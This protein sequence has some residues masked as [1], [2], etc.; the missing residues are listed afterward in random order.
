[1][2]V[3]EKTTIRLT[4]TY[5]NFRSHFHPNSTKKLKKA[6]FWNKGKRKKVRF[7]A[8]KQFP[9]KKIAKKTSI[10]D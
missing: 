6:S 7:F 3:A 9:K 5:T 1:M 8:K 2:K 4:I 10:R